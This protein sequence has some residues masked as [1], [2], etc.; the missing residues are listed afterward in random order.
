LGH[1]RIYIH[2][3]G[4]QGLENANAGGS[5]FKKKKILT[6][7]FTNLEKGTNI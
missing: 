1:K 7:N 3:L 2:V 6:E 5:S 4:L